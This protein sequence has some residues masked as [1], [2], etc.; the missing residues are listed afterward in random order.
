M[1]LNNQKKGFT[2]IEVLLAATIFTIVSMIVATVFVN[3]LRIQKRIVL[4]NAIYEDARF[5][6]ERISR[7]LR[8]NT[9]D[10]EEYYNKTL[11]KEPVFA[12]TTKNHY[13][14]R[15]GCYSKRF[16]NPGSDG[17]EA[18]NFGAKC[19][20]N[21]DPVTNPEC[22]INK[23]TLDINTGQNPYQGNN[24]SDKNPVDASAFCDKNYSISASCAAFNNKQSELYLINGKGTE[25]T[26]LALKE[27]NS[28]TG[29]KGLGLLRLE[30]EDQDLDS[31]TEVW[32]N[33]TNNTLCCAS[34][35][36]CSGIT[37]LENTLTSPGTNLYKGFVLI[38]PTR[39]Q[40]LSLDF[41]VSPLEDPRKAFAETDAVTQQQPHV[42]IILKVKPAESM[43]TGYSGDIPSITLQTT[44]TS[45]VYN[46][47]KSFYSKPGSSGVCNMYL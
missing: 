44:V 21:S 18:G 29:E 4:E 16:Y 41:Y 1:G 15:Y 33:C 5:M 43:L 27:F 9:I 19:N 25:K 17:N 30:G 7:E 20:D 47:V 36:D 14:N 37:S 22:I 2:L 13:G 24:Y 23:N 26:L 11:P 40:V 6:M 39:T 46:E 3:I 28:T 12:D 8:Q 42:T 38:S 34:G 10:Y 45:R 32:N 31:I 35:F